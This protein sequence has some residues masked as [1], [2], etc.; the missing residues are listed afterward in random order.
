MER[1]NSFLIT[2]DHEISIK[3]FILCSKHNKYSHYFKPPRYFALGYNFNISSHCT[4]N[5]SEIGYTNL[6]DNVLVVILAKV[7]INITFYKKINKSRTWYMPAGT[8]EHLFRFLCNF[9]INIIKSFISFIK[10]KPDI[11]IATGAH[12]CH[13]IKITIFNNKSIFSIFNNIQWPLCTIKWNTRYPI[14][15]CF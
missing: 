5:K 9:P 4:K 7:S 6:P 8:K 10:V 11:I 3:T 13:I 15:H 12:T 2:E 1:Y 14:A